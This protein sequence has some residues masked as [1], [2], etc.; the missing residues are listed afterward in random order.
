MEM[1]LTGK[2]RGGLHYPGILEPGLWY[3]CRDFDK[4][5][6]CMRWGQI[7]TYRLVEYEK[8]DELLPGEEL[9][10]ACDTRH[11]IHKI[12]GETTL[13]VGRHLSYIEWPISH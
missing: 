9:D 2:Y 7:G 5:L 8:G 6:Y 4:I 12:A 10:L 3:V 11:A 13:K 1:V